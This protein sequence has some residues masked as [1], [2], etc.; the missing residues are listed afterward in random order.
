[1]QHHQ[2]RDHKPCP[3]P[4]FSLHWGRVVVRKNL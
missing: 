4:Q 3:V 2:P 1:M